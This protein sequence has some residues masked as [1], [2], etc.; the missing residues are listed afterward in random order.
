MKANV[1]FRAVVIPRGSHVVRFS[2]HPF[3]GALAEI[4]AKFTSSPSGGK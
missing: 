1:I 2:F 3:A 4:K